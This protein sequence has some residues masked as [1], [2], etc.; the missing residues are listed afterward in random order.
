[1][2][3]LSTGKTILVSLLVLLVLT[4]LWSVGVY[5]GFVSSDESVNEK[6]ANVQSAYQLRADKIPNLV[7][8]VKAYSDYEG[9]VLT[10]ITQARAAIMSAKT[11][12][13]LEAADSQ[14]SSSLKSLFAVVENY[15][16]LK[17]NEN[18]LSLQDELAGTENRIKTERDIFNKAV[19]EYNINVRAFPKNVLAGM[20]GFTQKEMFEAAAGA[21]TAPSVKDLMK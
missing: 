15:P 19:K 14:L 3:K 5:N 18:Y 7:A 1:M 20:F 11:P 8:I 2:K 17:A 9:T 10:E 12:A 21:E 6:W 13:Q 4:A 16:D